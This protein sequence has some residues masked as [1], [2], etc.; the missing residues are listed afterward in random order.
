MKKTTIVMPSTQKILKEMGEQ[1]R[2]ARLRRRISVQLL[3]ERASIS[4]STLWAIENGVPTVSIGAYAAALHGLNYMDRD[5]LLVAKD[6]EL[7]RLLQDLALPKRIRE[8]K[9]DNADN[10]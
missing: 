1:I 9:K 6:D 8:R 3:C 4:R 10:A 5:L 7:A 2:A